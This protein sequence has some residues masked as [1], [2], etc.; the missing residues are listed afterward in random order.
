LQ[1]LGGAMV[2]VV[3]RIL[4]AMDVDVALVDIPLVAAIDIDA[5]KKLYFN[6]KMDS[7]KQ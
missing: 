1:T 5:S 3:I 4:D 2:A 7:I 6:Q